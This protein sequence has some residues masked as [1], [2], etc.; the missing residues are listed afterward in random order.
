VVRL[1]QHRRRQEQRRQDV[2]E[3]EARQQGAARDLFSSCCDHRDLYFN[4]EGTK[5]RRQQEPAL[6]MFVPLWSRFLVSRQPE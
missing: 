4:R 5:T 1:P 6:R 2:P 3:L